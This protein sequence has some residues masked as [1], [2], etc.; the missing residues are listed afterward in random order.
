MV[1]RTLLVGVIGFASGV[2]CRSFF[3]LPWSVIALSSVVGIALLVL[4]RLRDA[5]SFLLTGVLLVAIAFGMG[6]AALAP[7]S[8]PESFAGHIG[9]AVELEGYIVADPDIRETTQRVTVAVEEG[10]ERMRVLVVTSLYPEL[11]YGERVAISGALKGPESFDTDGGRVF[12]YDRFLAKDGVFGIV[13]YGSIEVLEAP[14]GL[15]RVQGTLFSLKHLFVSGLERALAE[16][17]ASLAAGLITG[18]KQG[19]GT[20]LV[21]AFIIAGL[22]H[23]VVLSGY[24]VMIVAEAVLRALGFL[25]KR[26][27]AGVAAL[28]IAL[29]VLAAGAGAASIRAGLM[30]G[31]ALFGRAS[32]RT[33]DALRALVFAGTLMLLAN[34][35]LL[36]FDPGFQLSFIATAGLILGAPMLGHWFVFIKSRFMREIVT[37][38][39]A[40]Q[41]AVLP[42]LL[43]QTGNLSLVALPANIL[44]LPVVPFA[45]LFSA[46]AALAGLIVSPLAPMLGAPAFLLLGYMIA[47]AEFAAGLP[48]A[49]VLLPQ[50]PFV[51]VLLLY[52]CMAGF[53][54]RLYKRL[55]PFGFL[56][57]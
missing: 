48:F 32:G 36:A 13:S 30:A 46:I 21:D 50:F 23:V 45:M 9:S 28:T 40:A 7:Q 16:P 29:F 1:D 10:G 15:M 39:V 8:A 17:Y 11:A 57:T 27:A 20:A 37:A 55:I 35:L 49:Q 6:R 26:A 2:A 22:I 14:H 43:Y 47:A 25:P 33:Y 34:P 51:L 31:I 38:T 18:G 53:V 42:L 5:R 12:R 19:L 24:N 56:K 54:W 41:I 3:I 44:V 52:A 4:W